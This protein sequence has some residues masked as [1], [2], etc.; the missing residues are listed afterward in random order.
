MMARGGYLNAGVFRAICLHGPQPHAA[1][2]NADPV[3][4][5]Y[6][7]PI[8]WDAGGEHCIHT[9]SAALVRA[10]VPLL[11]EEGYSFVRPDRMPEYKQYETPQSQP[12]VASAGGVGSRV[13]AR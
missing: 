12:V 6:V 8:Y 13:I 9:Q 4:K 7:G 2:L 11:V 3:L 1:V 10:V 5:K